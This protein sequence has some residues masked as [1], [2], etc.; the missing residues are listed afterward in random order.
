MP[1]SQ[2]AETVVVVT[3]SFEG[4]AVD[5][6]GNLIAEA[7]GLRPARLVVDL[8]RSPR[9]DA[10]A[11]GVLLQA[12]RAMISAGGVLALR[13]PGERIRHVLRLARLT[14]VFAI[15]RPEAVPA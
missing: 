6:W 1:V 15:E 8:R 12:H 10:A 9:V 13:A 2:I 3:E 14:H 11:L 7:V 5:R 4:E